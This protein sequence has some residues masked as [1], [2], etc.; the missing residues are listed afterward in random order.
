MFS[1]LIIS[2]LVI[3][4]YY[5]YKP[6][7]KYKTLL[8]TLVWAVVGISLFENAPSFLFPFLK[9]YVGFSFFYVVMIA[10][11]LPT[12]WKLTKVLKAIRAP[13]SIVG[14]IVLLVHPLNYA[15]EV[16]AQTRAIP[17]FGVLAFVVMI[18][19]FVT[20]YMVVRKKMKPKSWKSLQKWAYLSYAALFVHLIIQASTT[21]NRIVAILLALV[22]VTLK[23]TKEIKQSK[24]A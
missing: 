2:M 3:L 19:L 5:L 21:Q 9:G 7:L 22:Y 14:F 24:K 16:L 17:T 6:I 10:G 12:Q 20:S 4:A 15:S 13:Y 18:P 1:P 11:A 23:L 8:Y